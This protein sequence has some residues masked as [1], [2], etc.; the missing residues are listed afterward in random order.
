MSTRANIVLDSNRYNRIWLYHHWDGYPS[1]LGVNLMNFL[2]DKSGKDAGYNEWYHD[3]IYL[4]NQLIKDK[5]DDGY[6]LTGGQHGDIDY[7]YKID[8]GSRTIWAYEVCSDGKLECLMH[9]KYEDE[10]ERKKWFEWCE[11][12]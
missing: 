9:V 1:G 7:L 12:H 6:E 4:A 10:E 11:K 8:T 3:S 2:A 5:D